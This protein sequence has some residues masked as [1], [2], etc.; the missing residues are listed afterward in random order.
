MIIEPKIESR[1]FSRYY[2]SLEPLWTRPAI[3]AYTMLILSFFTMAFFGYFAIRPTMTTISALRRQISDAKFVDQQLQNKINAL[4]Q[5]QVAYEAIKPDLPVVMTALPRQPQF[6]SFVKSLEKISSESN[7]TVVSLRFQSV[8]LSPSEATASAQ[9]IP[10]GF[11]LTT[12]GDYNSLAGFVKRL[13]YFER[14]A[15][16]ERVQLLMKNDETGKETLQ[17]SLLGKTFYV[18]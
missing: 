3:R 11:S 6:P 4:S 8:S 5:V 16:I 10:I 13:S 9:E 2:T 18:E 1:R 12:S 14:I 7:A 17:L 15:V